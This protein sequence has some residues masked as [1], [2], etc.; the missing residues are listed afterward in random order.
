MLSCLQF[1]LGEF[2]LKVKLNSDL[3]HFSWMTRKAYT[4]QSHDHTLILVP[5]VYTLDHRSHE[6]A[7]GLAAHLDVIVDKSIP[8]ITK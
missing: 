5:A 7:L 3:I 2:F 4:H 6:H 8:K 1:A